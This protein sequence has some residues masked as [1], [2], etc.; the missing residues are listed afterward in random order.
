MFFFKEKFKYLWPRTVFVIFLSQ[1]HPI[2]RTNLMETQRQQIPLLSWKAVTAWWRISYC[3]YADEQSG[4]WGYL[5]KSNWAKF[6]LKSGRYIFR[7][8]IN[9]ISGVRMEVRVVYNFWCNKI[10][11]F[12]V[13]MWW[14]TRT[15]V[16]TNTMTGLLSSQLIYIVPLI[17]RTWFHS[18][19]LPLWTSLITWTRSFFCLFM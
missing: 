7:K 3:A 18:A 17:F 14:L 5:R 1:I 4:S 11:I 9:Q 16:V 19:R 2:I 15:L 8:N 12:S 10:F 6:T 13:P